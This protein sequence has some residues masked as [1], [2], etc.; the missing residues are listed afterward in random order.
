[1]GLPPPN[2]A[3]RS[4][5]VYCGAEHKSD[6]SSE[7]L[8][9]ALAQSSRESGTC[10]VE[11]AARIPM[12]DEAVLTLLREHFANSADSGRVLV[13][14]HILPKKEEA[15]R[16]AH[17]IHLPD[18]ERILALYDSHAAWFDGGD[19]GFLVTSRRL[20]WKNAGESAYAIEWRDL[21]PEQLETY[22]GGLAIGNDS[23]RIAD[24]DVVDAC[25]NAFHVLALSGMP[26]MPHPAHS[27]RAPRQESVPPARRSAM[28]TPPPPHNTSFAHYAS[29]VESQ[30]PDHACWHCRTPLYASTPQCAYCGALPKKRKGWLRAG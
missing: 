8:A 7:V 29:H 30:A 5:C 24:E 10:A 26:R 28:T 17:A 20:C 4:S 16:R 3:G 6:R 25:A 2:A 27:G 11:D 14:P 13:C 23:I 18:R 1:M 12:T 22:P 15:A 9:I 21:D 19:E